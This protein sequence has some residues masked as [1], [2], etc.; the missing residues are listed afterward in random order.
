MQTEPEED[1]QNLLKGGGAL[2]SPKTVE[3]KMHK[4]SLCRV[5][6]LGL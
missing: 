6:G 5:Q 4:G 2:R 3:T 1:A